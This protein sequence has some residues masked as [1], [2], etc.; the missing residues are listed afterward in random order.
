MLP[1]SQRPAQGS[2]A[3]DLSKDGSTFQSSRSFN[4]FLH[5]YMG[6]L[7]FSPKCAF[8]TQLEAQ[9]VTTD[10]VDELQWLSLATMDMDT[11]NETTRF[12]GVKYATRSKLLALVHR[13]EGDI[14]AASEKS[15]SFF[16]LED[17][18]ESI[19]KMSCTPDAMFYNKAVNGGPRILR[20]IWEDKGENVSAASGWRQASLYAGSVLLHLLRLGVSPKDALVP[21]AVYTGRTLQ[22]G[23]VGTN[24]VVTKENVLN[25]V[26]QIH[27]VSKQL[28]L[29]NASDMTTATQGIHAMLNIC[30]TKLKIGEKLD[31]KISGAPL[32]E[33]KELWFKRVWG[34]WGTWTG[35]TLNAYADVEGSDEE[36]VD[37]VKKINEARIQLSVRR[38][39]ACLDRLYANDSVRDNVVFPLG[40]VELSDDYYI[41]FPKLCDK[42]RIGMPG[43]T[44]ECKRVCAAIVET[45]M[46][47]SAAN[48]VHM[49]LYP[50]NIMWCWKHDSGEDGKEVQVKVV[51]WDTCCFKKT[52]LPKAMVS[53]LRNSPRAHLVEEE[54]DH[55]ASEAHD[56]FYM[57][58][59]KAYRDDNS[60]KTT[61]ASELNEAFRKLA[62]SYSRDPRHSSLTTQLS[63][64]RLA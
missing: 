19:I 40:F 36:E 10:E 14:E 32:Q 46:A 53:A 16:D 59:L 2:K 13:Y 35:A 30:A 49:D 31:V 45:Q 25:V 39:L 52:P 15:F 21:F 51:D 56:V 20:A 44:D 63:N 61:D 3:S 50:S 7:R 27:V 34:N 5:L 54:G 12:F 33:S 38:M 26:P 60:L 42:W 64:V 4:A 24:H 58:V 62:F 9:P 47:I 17:T 41:S 43:T 11:I 18:P 1:P 55:E 29:M 8:Q 22:F 28:D 57:D 37:D 23:S 48:V 6:E